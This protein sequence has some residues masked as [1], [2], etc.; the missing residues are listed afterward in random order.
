MFDNSACL[1]G[2]VTILN[3]LEKYAFESHVA[4]HFFKIKNIF[5]CPYRSFYEN[6]IPLWINGRREVRKGVV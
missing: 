2:S 4:L 3:S 1:L 5:L 6:L